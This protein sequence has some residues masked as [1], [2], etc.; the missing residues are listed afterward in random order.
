MKISTALSISGVCALA[1]VAEG[2]LAYLVF[3]NYAYSLAETGQYAMGEAYSS[4]PM[5]RVARFFYVLFGITAAV[6]IG[7]PILASVIHLW[8][9]GKSRD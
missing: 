3:S 4:G 8:G 1:L 9:R 5:A 6:G 7:M 2:L